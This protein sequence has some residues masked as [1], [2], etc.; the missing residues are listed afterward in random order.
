[1]AKG[2]KVDQEEFD[3]PET[4]FIRDIENRVFQ[5]IVLQCLAKIEGV[6][7]LEGNLIDHLLGR[8]SVER[9][10]GILIEQDSKTHSV[11][12]KVEVNI[13]Y[14]ILIPDKAEE[15]QKRIIQE[16]TKIT[17]LRVSCVHVVFKGMIIDEPAS[18]E[19]KAKGNRWEPLMEKIKGPSNEDED[20]SDTF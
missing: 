10:K 17:G 1:M 4:H 18:E 14:G 19:P 7:I 6:G 12:I 3:L 15:I 13:K 5:A 9:V 8:T 20:Y 11:S 2:S 16:V